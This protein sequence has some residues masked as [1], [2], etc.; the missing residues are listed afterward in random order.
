MYIT[1]KR[2]KPC[3]QSSFRQW[4]VKSQFYADFDVR[5]G[6]LCSFQTTTDLG[7]AFAPELIVVHGRV[8]LMTAHKGKNLVPGIENWPEVP[9]SVG[10]ARRRGLANH[11]RP[12]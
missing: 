11:N 9:P 3:L 8:Y 7:V 4:T 5:T 12:Y 6:I 10:R 2:P 1:L